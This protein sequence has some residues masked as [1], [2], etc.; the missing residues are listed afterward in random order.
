MRALA[1][2]WL[3][4]APKPIF[5]GGCFLLSTVS[6]FDARPGRTR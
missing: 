1:E 3:D 6:E 2:S 4:Y 5:G